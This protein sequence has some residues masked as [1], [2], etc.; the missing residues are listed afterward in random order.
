[1]GFREYRQLI[2]L[3]MRKKLKELNWDEDEDD[4]RDKQAGHGSRTAG[5]RYDLTSDD[6]AGLTPDELLAFF[7][8]SQEWHRL[9]GFKSKI[10]SRMTISQENEEGKKRARE[11]ENEIRERLE[12]VE[13][14]LSKLVNMTPGRGHSRV[15]T[16]VPLPPLWSDPRMSVSAKVLRALR[17]FRGDRN[18]RFK[19]PEQGQALQLI[20]EGK[21]DVLAILPTGGGKSLLFFLPTMLEPGMTT[22]VIV[23]LIA[24]MDDLRDRCTQAGIS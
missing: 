4:V 10:E 24:V 17:K 22:V 16:P 13:E 12:K 7:R 1:M 2:K 14:R 15:M 8:V 9:L 6:M 18:A 23:P 20:L 21:K 5:L 11:G 3:F 19:S